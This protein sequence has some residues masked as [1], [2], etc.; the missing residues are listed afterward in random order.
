MVRQLSA[1]HC[2]G[3]YLPF[4]F[5][6]FFFLL[7]FFSLLVADFLVYLFFSC[8]LMYFF[9]NPLDDRSSDHYDQ[10][11]S[12]PDFSTTSIKLLDYIKVRQI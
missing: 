4:L 7:F 3:P 11:V 6:L 1:A 2:Q 8:Q 12:L 5:F 9:F 10:E